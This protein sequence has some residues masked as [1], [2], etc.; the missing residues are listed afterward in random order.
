MRMKKVALIEEEIS[1]VG[2]GCWATGGADVWNNTTD[3]GSIA[4]IQ[5]AVDLGV[6]FFDVA[7]V[8][9]LGHAETVL[10]QALRGRRQKVLIA[11]KCGLVWDEQKRVRNDLTA[12]SLHQEIDTSLQ[13]LQ[14]D[15]IDLYQIHW[16]D[17]NTPIA[18]TMAA[19]EA[20]KQ[21]GKIRHIGVSNFSLALTQ[22]AM[23]HGTVVSHQGLYNMLERNPDSY[24]NIPLAYRVEDEILP[25]CQQQGMAFLPYSPI[26][27]GLLTDGFQAS[28][29]FDSNDVRSANP[30]LNGE[31]FH[32]YFGMREALRGFAERIKRPLSQIA[33]NWLIEQE[34]VTSVICGAQ[35]VAHVAENTGSQS[36]QLT[37]DMMAEVE[38][39]LAPYKA[40]IMG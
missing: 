28:G 37:D 33:I 22:E 30:K 31:R 35:T 14:T 34:A 16:P 6:N 19:L 21:S 3:Q 5:R 23:Q 15:Y 20:I 1:A 38:A 24:H 2:F 17:P 4:A 11:T 18:E 29:N 7:P 32:T 26:F 36:W 12:V 25:F 10:G 40:E 27:Q 39:I 9:G 8:Y 13:R